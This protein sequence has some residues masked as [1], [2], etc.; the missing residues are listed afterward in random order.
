MPELGIAG[1]R[2][3]PALAASADAMA[4]LSLWAQCRGASGGAIAM[5]GAGVVQLPDQPPALPFAG[6]VADQPA[7]VM[8]AFAILDAAYRALKPKP[9]EG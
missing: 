8:R 1:L 3:H 6:G 5:A 9:G 7:C 4:V 2:Q